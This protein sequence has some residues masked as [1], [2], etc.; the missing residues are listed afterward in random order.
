MTVHRSA[1]TPGPSSGISPSWSHKRRIEAS[2][3]AVLSGRI[4]TWTPLPPHATPADSVSEAL[5]PTRQPPD[6]EDSHMKIMCRRL[7]MTAFLLAPSLL[8]PAQ[9]QVAL[10][11]IAV[12]VQVGW[13]H[14]ASTVGYMLFYPKGLPAAL[15]DYAYALSEVQ[16]PVTCTNEI[17]DEAGN[18]DLGHVVVARVEEGASYPG[19]ALTTEPGTMV[20][21]NAQD[22]ADLPNLNLHGLC[23]WLTGDQ[24]ATLVEE[25]VDD[26]DRV[27]EMQ[28]LLIT[29]YPIPND[30]L[31]IQSRVDTWMA[32]N[33][34]ADAREP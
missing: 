16:H 26:A 29:D 5:P 12:P 21:P 7:L 31:E 19:F 20:E 2:M 24:L 32:R 28:W 6:T 25:L 4:V 34:P 30:N 14:I 10:S 18:L 17:L 33:Q 22:E 13:S 9:A 1:R 23:A 27:D 3:S 15:P 8:A 11:V